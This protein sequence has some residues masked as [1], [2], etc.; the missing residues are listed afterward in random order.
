MRIAIIGS[1]IAGLTAA[2]LLHPVHDVHLFEADDRP[3]GHANTVSVTLDAKVVAADTGFLVYNERTYPRF[4]RLLAELGVATHESD[5]SFSLTDRSRG[6]EWRGSTLNTVFAQR[7]NALRPGFLAMLAD[8]ARF[9]RLARRLLADPSAPSGTLADLLAQHRWSRGFLEWYLVPMGSAIWSANPTTFTDIPARTF[10]EF[11]SRHGLLS[12]GDQPQWRTV[13]GGSVRYVEALLAPLKRRGRVHLGTAVAKVRGEAGR[14]EIVG[15]WGTAEFD[16]VVLAV[17]SD[18]ALALLADPT[19]EER[20]ALGSIGYHKNR[21]TLHTDTRLMPTN[22]RAWAS[23]NYLRQQG[24]TSLPTLTYHLN[25]LQGLDAE[26]PILVTLNR[27]EEIDPA[28]VL[29]RFEYAHPEI[30]RAAVAAQPRQLAL[31]RQDRSF[32]GAYWGYG[33]HEDGVNSAVSVCERLGV[34]W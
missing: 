1:G 21:A 4:S 13:T 18:Q 16:H 32:C 5:M 22:R 20:M 10:A 23:W 9:N 28:L 12:L 33:F 11:F 2:H 8:V 15:E 3:G 24:P 34:S 17:H 6:I 7:R 19:P 14:A 27:D 25:A 30:D 26:R 29:R 31:V